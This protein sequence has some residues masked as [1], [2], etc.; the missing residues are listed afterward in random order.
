MPTKHYQPCV[1]QKTQTSS[2]HQTLRYNQRAEQ[3]YKKPYL[4]TNQNVSTMNHATAENIK[5]A[6]GVDIDKCYQC[7]KCTAGCVLADNMDYPSSMIIRMLQTDDK[8][9]YKKILS[10]EAIWL[11]QNCENCI[12]RCP[13]EVDIPR[14]MDYLRSES[15]REGLVSA[16]AKPQLSF[17]RSFL[18]TVKLSGRLSEVVMTI[19]F[20]F[21]TL[22]LWQDVKLVPSMLAKGK[23]KFIPESVKDKK[24]F[25]NI[26]KKTTISKS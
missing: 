22:R 21:R 7:G 10:S 9:N 2:R 5:H 16:K 24:G 4:T 6:I 13:K 15:I 3:G 11:C 1:N 23:L 12:G 18:N 20:K 25:K 8:E 19:D 26:F 14:I 17:Y